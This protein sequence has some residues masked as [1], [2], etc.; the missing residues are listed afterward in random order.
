MV[1][2]LQAVHRPLTLQ[3]EAAIEAPRLHPLFM[4]QPP[5]VRGAWLRTGEDWLHLCALVWEPVIRVAFSQRF[6]TRPSICSSFS[7]L[8]SAFFL[9]GHEVADAQSLAELPDSP[10]AA[11]TTASPG[12]ATGSREASPGGGVA[13]GLAAAAEEEPLLAWLPATEAALAW[14]MQCLDASL[15][16]GAAEGQPAAR[17]GLEGYQ[18]IQR[19]TAA[20][21]ACGQPLSTCQF[22]MLPN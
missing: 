4:R 7:F 2:D 9:P 14:R 17:E 20:G 6:L 15:L 22:L 1:A 18:F 11:A 5:L 19:P 21:V 3:L 12:V 16:Y 8:S 10:G 13:A